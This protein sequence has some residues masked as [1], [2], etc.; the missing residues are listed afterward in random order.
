L[1]SIEDA[2]VAEPWSTHAEALRASDVRGPLVVLTLAGD[3]DEDA[4]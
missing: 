4:A 1:G 2:H 3:V